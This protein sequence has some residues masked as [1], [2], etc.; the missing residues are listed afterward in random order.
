MLN[1]IK[2]LAGDTMVYG[3]FQIIGRFLTFLLTPLYTNYLSSTELA[4]VTYLYAII[5]FLNII[6]SFGIESS[7]FR[8]FDRKNPEEAK[9]IFSN[10]FMIIGSIAIATCVVVIATADLFAA[11]FIQIKNP[12]TLIRLAILIP[13]FDSLIFIPYAYLRMTRNAKKFAMTRFIVII[14]AVINNFIFVVYMKTGAMGVIL[15]QLIASSIAILI[16]WKE[17]SGNLTLKPDFKLMKEMIL[18]GLPTL[19]ANISAIILQVADRPFLKAF[20]SM[21]DLAIYSVNY[22]LAIPMMIV[23]TVFDY[24]WKPFYMSRYEDEGAM[25][26]FARIFTYFTLVCSAVFLATSFFIEFVVKMPFIGGRFVAQ[27]YW[28]GL[29]VVPIILAAFFLNGAQSHFSAGFLITK[30][31][32]YTGISVGFG[33]IVSIILNFIL[34]PLFSYWG[35]AIAILTGYAVGATTLFSFQRR[36]Y[37]IKYEWKRVATIIVST[38]IVFFAGKAITEGMPMSYSFS[39]RMGFL[40]IYLLLLYLF[41][42]FTLSEISGIKRMLKF[43]SLRKKNIS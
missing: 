26:L 27:S 2:S 16:V 5:A 18:F 8:F 40:V 12:A 13:V 42:F 32:K 11:D 33:A 9:R 39:I 25:D 6:F 19:P 17:I 15:S 41:R 3:F 14:I 4:E 23:V 34:I 24:A 29:G 20:A 28:V 7:F 30:N 31:T 43:K 38:A 1:K 10:A 22:K 36:F 37:P 35:S 21:H